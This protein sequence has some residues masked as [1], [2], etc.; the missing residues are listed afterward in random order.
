[1]AGKNFA[2]N[3]KIGA[4]MSASVGRVFGALKTKIK[5][6]ENTLK[7]LRAAYKDASKGTGEYAG[8]LDELKGKIKSA[9]DELKKL[10]KAAKFDIGKAFKG[11]GSTFMDDAKRLA[12]GA[13]IIVGAATAVG[14]AVYSVTKGFVDW[15]DDIG[16]SA[17]ALGISTQALQTWQFAAATVGVEGSKMTAS[18]AKFS[19]AVT[20]GG[21]ATDEAFGKLGINVKRLKKLSLDDQLKVTAEAFSRYKGVD[22]VALSM[23]LFGKSGYQLAGIL[24]K[25]AKGFDEFKKMGEETGAVLTDDAAKAAGDAAAALDTF[26]ITMTGLR[27]TIAIQF[28]PVLQ[29]LV[30][31]FTG[32]VRGEG[33]RIREWAS[34][35][36]ATIEEK[37]VPAL[38]RFIDKLPSIIDQ[39]GDIATKFWTV[40]T[41]VKDFLGG[42]DNLG[43]ALVALNFA[44]TIAAI[45]SMTTGVLAMT[46]ATWAAVAP[47]LAIGAAIGAVYLILTN[48][49]KVGAWFETMMGTENFDAIGQKL[50]ELEQWFDGLKDAFVRDAE[51]I[52][53]TWAKVYLLTDKFFRDMKDAAQLAVVKIKEA[54]AELFGWLE[55]QWN[56]VGAA[57]DEMWNRAKSLGDKVKNFFSF[58][59]AS[60]QAPA[61]APPE[62]M[63]ARDTRTSMNNKVDIH[64]QTA[65]TDGRAFGQQLRQ[66]LQRKPLFDMDGAL[67]PS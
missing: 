61:I 39:V 59:P 31:R 66:E 48:K 36:A 67:V 50:Y 33:P 53:E 62:A 38:G 54:F 40:L 1:M 14:G 37:V 12:L 27:N 46:G 6:Q 32:F 22:K 56:R 44:P 5:E 3:L 42:W 10:Q 58:S 52:G 30:E 63:P 64:V 19:K 20:D 25:G 11:I 23:K 26:G 8:R 55:A 15:A 24:S 47:W 49:E 17:E 28:V 7:G 34:K 2:A 18:I 35:F 65:A 4:V 57:I 16:D 29:K 60:V 9:E 45:G 21:K 13:G 51:K 43:I 41:S